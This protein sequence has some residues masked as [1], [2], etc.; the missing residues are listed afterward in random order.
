MHWLLF[1]LLFGVTIVIFYQDFTTRSVVWFLFPV[2]SIVGIIHNYQQGNSWRTILINSSI[3]MGFLVLQF[4]L[5]SFYFLLKGQNIR[6]SLRSKLG[7]GD[8]LFML[9][10]CFFFSPLNFLLFYCS[11]LFFS[12]FIHLFVIQFF[13]SQKDTHTIPLAGWQAIFLCLFAGVFVFLQSS[14]LN[15]AWLLNYFLLA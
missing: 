5:L 2:I 10:C 9:A 3:N 11:S 1:L 6:N 8:I 7:L 15:D 12:L 4:L 14:M 13:R